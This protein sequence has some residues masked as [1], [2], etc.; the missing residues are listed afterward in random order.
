[1]RAR[2]FYF[3]MAR[4]RPRGDRRLG[5]FQSPRWFSW[6]WAVGGKLAEFLA[7]KHD[8]A[9]DRAQN[10]GKGLEKRALAGAVA[11]DEGDQFTLADAEIDPAHRLDGPLAHPQIAHFQHWHHHSARHG[12]RRAPHVLPARPDML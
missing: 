4:R 1:M 10:S 2:R 3:L 7:V 11:A 8:A 5:Y 12:L 6:P 9:A